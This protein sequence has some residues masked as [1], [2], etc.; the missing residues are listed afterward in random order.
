VKGQK[1]DLD[2]VFEV[3][4]RYLDVYLLHGKAALKPEEAEL[5]AV[6]LLDAEVNNGGF[7][8]YF[9]NTL[10]DLISEAIE[11]LENIGAEDLASIADAAAAELPDNFASSSPERRREQIDE[12][13]ASWGSRLGCYDTQYYESKDDPIQLL[14]AYIRENHLP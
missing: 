3:T 14:A 8:Q 5:L 12:L 1:D 2:L 6:W 10:G 13:L 7:N 4:N 11:G 9:G